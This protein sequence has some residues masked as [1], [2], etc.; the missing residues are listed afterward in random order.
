ML[1]SRRRQPKQ[2]RGWAFL[3]RHPHLPHAL[4]YRSEDE[5]LQAISAIEVVEDKDSPIARPS[6]H[7]SA[8]Y[9]GAREGE[10]RACTDDELERVRVAFQMDGADE[11]NHGEGI[12]RHLWLDCDKRVE[13]LCACKQD[14]ETF[15]DGSREWRA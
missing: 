15:V 1:A 7:V 14:E 9:L 5:P 2:P 8:I 3:G 11:D 10:E 13:D 4:I 12:A 6:Y